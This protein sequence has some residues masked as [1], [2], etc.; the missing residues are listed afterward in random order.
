MVNP[1][2]IKEVAKNSYK[3]F[4]KYR[5]DISEDPLSIEIDKLQKEKEK[6]TASIGLIGK[7]Y[8]NLGDTTTDIKENVMNYLSV[9][10]GI[11][12]PCARYNLLIPKKTYFYTD[13]KRVK[14]IKT[15]QECDLIEKIYPQPQKAIQTIEEI[16]QDHI[17][18]SQDYGYIQ[19][20]KKRKKEIIRELILLKKRMI[21][22][23]YAGMEYSPVQK[24]LAQTVTEM[25]TVEHDYKMN[26]EELKY[27]RAVH[28][29]K[30]GTKVA[31][32]ATITIAAS[33]LIGSRLKMPKK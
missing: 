6:W 16:I 24:E 18:G 31:A 11:V 12:M 5:K 25:V 26:I 32:A 8:P 22:P 30:K 17:T 21:S 7:K 23:Y 14:E 20:F 29:L 9:I 4:K 19:G 28:R 2:L 3:A 33:L 27:Q 10:E 13:A 1:M 15:S